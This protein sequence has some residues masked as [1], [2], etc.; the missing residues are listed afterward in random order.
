MARNLAYTSDIAQVG[1]EKMS[2]DLEWTGQ[3]AFTEKSLTQWEVDGKVAG[4]TRSANGFTFATI[5]GAGHMV[6]S[7][8]V[9]CGRSA[10]EMLNYCRRFRTIS[11]RSL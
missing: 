7:N 11:R 3:K 6:Q 4:V 5:N 2:L 8:Q 9:L 1:N 10:A